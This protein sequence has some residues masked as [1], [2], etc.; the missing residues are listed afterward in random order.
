VKAAIY[1]RV[2]TDEQVRE[3]T[4]LSV[5]R[6]QASAYVTARG[7]SLV[8]EFVDEGVSGAKESRPDLDRL[9][10]ACRKKEVEVVV[11]TKLDRFSRSVKHFVNAVAELDALGV[12]FVSV[13]EGFD[14]N[15]LTGQLLRNILASFADFERG[16]ITERSMSGRR[17]RAR[18]GIWVGGPPPFGHQ[19]QQKRLA[20]NED[21]AETIRRAVE[22]VSQTGTTLAEVAEMLNHEGRLPRSRNP[23]WREEREARWD[24]DNLRR[25]LL[26][27]TLVGT[28]T[29][30]KGDDA[31]AYEIPAILDNAQFRALKKTLT[32]TSRG[33]YKHRQVYPLSGRLVSA[34][35]ETYSGMYDHRSGIRYYRCRG[36]EEA[37]RCGCKILKAKDV[38][39][40]V[41][42]QIVPL[43]EDPERLLAIT[44]LDKEDDENAAQATLRQ[45]DAKIATLERAVTERAADALTHG[46]APDLIASAVAHLQ[47]QLETLRSR[48]EKLDSW[49]KV[50]DER[51]MRKS[52][53]STLSR[54]S[55]KLATPT[56]EFER[57]LLRLLDVRATITE[58]GVEISGVLREDLPERLHIVPASVDAGS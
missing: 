40:K 45:M 6:Q 28:Y 42:W 19:V 4:S 26:S 48:R 54:A 58:E 50:A 56:L 9:M 51:K 14:S 20:V 30:G 46:L 57:S 12:S 21:E 36:A 47:G 15:E 13:T 52:R 7:W 34:C 38:E 53:L 17:A 41:W 16:R 33:P 31:I 24:S 25:T 11:V 32:V 2:S 18:E 5:Q 3:G 29:W 43:F 23:R 22:L 44:G 37:P 8:H 55:L 1:C 27:E 39:K 49:Q 10:G 35:G